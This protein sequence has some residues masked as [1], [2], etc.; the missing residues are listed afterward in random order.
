M[1]AETRSRL[2]YAAGG[3]S[4][5]GLI[6][7]AFVGSWE[8]ES[9][10]AYRDIVGVPTICFGETRGVRIGDRETHAGCV[11][12]LGNRLVEFETGV[13]RCL[14]HPE[15]IPDKSYAAMISVAYNIGVTAFCGSTMARRLNAGDVA[16]ACDA[17]TA[18]N[19]AGG[20]VVTGLV[21]RRAAE[22]ALCR[23]GLPG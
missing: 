20:K 19:K 1:K 15:K 11:R 8:G 23:E 4:G 12:M 3:L 10:V 7:A 9:T 2:G 18:W 14:D 13:D 5:L 21:R 17:L 22:R 16:G 6:V